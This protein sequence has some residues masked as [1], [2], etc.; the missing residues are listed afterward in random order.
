MFVAPAFAQEQV[1][2]TETPPITEGIVEHA[3]VEHKGVFPPFET[4]LFPSQLLWLAITF[5]LFYIFLKKVVLPRLGHVLEVRRD[6]I[7]QDLDTASRMQEEADAAVA[8]YEQELAAARK[9]A[10]LIA[11][12]AN[13]RAKAEAEE[14]RKVS[15]AALQ[16]KLQQ[17]EARI[18]A[19]KQAAMSEVGAIAEE[20]ASA[21][22]EQL[23][24]KSN[25]A[26]IAQAVAAERG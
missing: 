16:D 25:S 2:V 22:V 14:S 9:R 20:T 7:A 19:I 6:R 8:A 13:D 12:E 11:N 21:I 24:G 18:A 26:A 3:G 10:T 17:A 5:G 1:P 4:T 15:E 23:G